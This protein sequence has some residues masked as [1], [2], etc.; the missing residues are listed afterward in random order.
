MHLASEVTLTWRGVARARVRT[1]L[2]MAGV[3]VGIC[4]LTVLDSV[5]A[6]TK[7]ETLRRFQNML[8]TFD[9]VII[10]PGAAR[11]RGMVS[12]TNVPP[13]LTFGD[14]A[15]I[16]SEIPEITQVAQVQ[17]AFDIDVKYRDHTDSPAVFGV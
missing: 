4:S 15:A 11:T 1:V 10:R 14:A 3:T 12:L 16:A 7:R 17:N 2:M 9:T 8:G 5:G 6:A 13:T